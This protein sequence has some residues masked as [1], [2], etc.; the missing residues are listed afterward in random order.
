[1]PKLLTRV[2]WGEWARPWTES[3][4]CLL[5]DGGWTQGQGS[6]SGDVPGSKEDRP[7][8]SLS[9]GFPRS[10]VTSAHPPTAPS[11]GASS[12]AAGLAWVHGWGGW[13]HSCSLHTATGL[14]GSWILGA[15]LSAKRGQRLLGSLA[16]TLRGAALGFEHGG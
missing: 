11:P 9:Q 5:Y 2:T 12:L 10:T 7:P 8:P 16:L 15:P 3:L 1:M 4:V 6:L 13:V 14:G